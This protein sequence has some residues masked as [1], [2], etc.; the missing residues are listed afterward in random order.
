M[1]RESFPRYAI[2]ANVWLAFNLSFKSYI[3]FVGLK[4]FMLPSHRSSGRFLTWRNSNVRSRT[5]C[6]H[7]M[8]RLWTQHLLP[9]HLLLCQRPC[10]H[11]E[12]SVW[13][14]M[15]WWSSGWCS[16]CHS[17]PGNM[18]SWTVP[19]VYPRAGR[20]LLVKKCLTCFILPAQA[21]L[22][23]LDCPRSW[24]WDSVVYS[25]IILSVSWLWGNDVYAVN[26]K[27]K[28]WCCKLWLRRDLLQNATSLG[29]LGTVRGCP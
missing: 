10:L 14:G 21:G 20:T 1:S 5:G 12:V 4:L 23:V 28:G 17:Q 7:Q 3:N 13:L 18:P 24:A 6:S 26:Q 27:C 25:Q 15:D 22:D 2:N 8:L 9:P 29:F 16:G 19:L 11:P